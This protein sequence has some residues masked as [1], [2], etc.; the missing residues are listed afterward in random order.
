[1]VVAVLAVG[2]AGPGAARGQAA[3][4]VS[5]RAPEHLYEVTLSAD[6]SEL[7]VSVTLAPADGASFCVGDGFGDFVRDLRVE[8]A[9]EGSA[10]FGPRVLLPSCV[11]GCR[12][13]YRFLLREAARATRRFARA[14]ESDDV[15][16]APPST[17]LLRPEEPREGSRV[18][19]RVRTPP[20]LSF[21][22]GLRP[23]GPAPGPRAS[24]ADEVAEY[25]AA[26]EDVASAPYAAFGPL[27]RRSIE[28]RGGRVELALT[29]G[30]R[31]LSDEALAAWARRSAETVAGLFGRFPLPRAAVL[32]ASGGRRAV[33]YGTTMGNGGAAVLISVGP[34]ATQADLERDWVLTHEL[35]HLALPNLPRRQRWLEEGF[36]TWAEPLARARAGW[37]SEKDLW[38]EWTEKMP[39]GA[40]AAESGLDAG[41]WA[42]V[43][44]GGAV[45][46]LLADVEIREASA[47][48][49]SLLD[50]LRAVLDAGGSIEVSWPRERFLSTIDGAAGAPVTSSLYERL[51]RRGERV[52]LAG[53]FDRLGV[54]GSGGSVAFDDTAQLAWLR[55]AMTQP[56]SP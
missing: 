18:R 36:A 43:Y 41:G 34:G 46:W 11:R 49:R 19:L 27:R 25:V 37:T 26:T 16:F 7:A 10:L 32:V 13:S 23:A 50:G 22:S 4:A 47:G 45:F 40:R 51:G 44:W 28:V 1:M 8:A 31:G 52:D 33:G 14:Y 20:G 5:P 3:Q 15:V 24:T 21:V 42:G 54:R 30:E 48:H 35:T 38:A 2:A 17:W 12:L 29:T 9:A 53:L 39:A 56:S 6:G 55:R